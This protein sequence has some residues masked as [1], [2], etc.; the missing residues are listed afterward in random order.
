MEKCHYIRIWKK[1]VK[2]DTKCQ[3]ERYVFKSE[4]WFYPFAVMDI[5]FLG[6]E[7]LKGPQKVTFLSAAK[8]N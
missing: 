2:I 7:C 6:G 4:A 1:S 3:T 5:L 8:S